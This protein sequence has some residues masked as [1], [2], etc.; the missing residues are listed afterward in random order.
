MVLNL[1]LLEVAD[2]VCS[3]FAS[4]NCD[5]VLKTLVEIACSIILCKGTTIDGRIGSL[6]SFP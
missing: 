2:T 3:K 4:E 5:N 6:L 1:M